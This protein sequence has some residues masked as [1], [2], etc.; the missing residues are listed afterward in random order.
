[1]TVNGDVIK[2]K[3]ITTAPALTGIRAQ[4]ATLFN[5]PQPSLYLKNKPKGISD[6]I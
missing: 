6:K 4:R 2:A 5:P 3:R 1:M